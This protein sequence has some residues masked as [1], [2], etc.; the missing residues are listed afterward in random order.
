MSVKFLDENGLSYFWGL[1]KAHV[2]SAIATVVNTVFYDGEA[3]KIKKTI[4]SSTTD[5]VSAS[6]IVTDGGA[7]K[8]V[9]VGSSTFTPSAGSNT[10]ELGDYLLKTD[11][12]EWAKAESKPTY[13]KSEVGLGNVTNDAQVKRTEMGAANGVATLDSNG[14]VPNSQLPGYVDD[15][16]EAYARTGQTALSSTW[17]ATGSAS[18]TVITPESG[19]IYVLMEAST[20][21]AANSQFRWG[22]STYVKMVDGGISAMSTSDID[23]ATSSNS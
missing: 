16:I 21:Y 20:P 19:K 14:L 13:T 22:G 6:T 15:V 23:S 2:T 4:G 12:A 11:I 17:L 7:V 1:I 18:G 10:V 5:V 9:K 3:K 8:S